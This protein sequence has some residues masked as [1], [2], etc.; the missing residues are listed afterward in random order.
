M[1][2][3][4]KSAG[5]GGKGKADLPTV[6]ASQTETAQAA[7][8]AGADVSTKAIASGHD[9]TVAA[10]KG[11]ENMTD[12]GKETVEAFVAVGTATAKGV[13]AINAEVLAFSKAHFEDSVAAAKAVLGAKT[14]KEVVDLQT[15]FAK[16]TFES[17]LQQSSKLGELTAKLTQEA[18]EPLN[19]R[20]QAAV[21]KFVKPLAA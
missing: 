14:L 18:F 9:R 1:T 16:S 7:I 4:T 11:Y 5:K 20:F 17:Y 21:E 2:S 15:D 8:K 12:F 10:A 3:K 13:E 6:V 19:A